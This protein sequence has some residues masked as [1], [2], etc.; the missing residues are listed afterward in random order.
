MEKLCEASIDCC[1]RK[2]GVDKGRDRK[3][4]QSFVINIIKWI[5]SKKAFRQARQRKFLSPFSE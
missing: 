5:L 4:D 2:E 1:K 3:N